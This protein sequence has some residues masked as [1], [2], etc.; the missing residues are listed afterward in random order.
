MDC[1]IKFRFWNSKG[2][3][4]SCKVTRPS[5]YAGLNDLYA[6]TITNGSSCLGVGLR[7]SCLVRYRYPILP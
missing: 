4:S 5:F 1:P 6:Y 2:I 3:G 7:W